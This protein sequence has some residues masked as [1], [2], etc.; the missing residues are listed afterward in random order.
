MK[1]QNILLL[2][3]LNLFSI[4]YSQGPS[5]S[6]AYIKTCYQNINC[7]SSG[8]ASSI[9]YS[10]GKQE[11]IILI[12]FK[13]FK[14]GID[15]LDEWLQDL[16][17]SKFTFIGHLD[18]DKLL[19]LNHHNFKTLSVNGKIKFNNI[20]HGHGVELVLYEISKEGILYT[21]NS[22]IYY[23]RIRAN[24][25]LIFYPKEFKINRKKHHLKKVI[26]IDIG[27]GYVNPLKPEWEHLTKVDF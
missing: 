10:E 25:Q 1:K 12:D 13:A 23:D 22:N 2:L 19:Q 16:E 5:V 27:K 24:V 14:T 20:V 26:S 3:L 17:D 15:S 9:F 21:E 8:N 6:N 11:L 18:K 4:F 7:F